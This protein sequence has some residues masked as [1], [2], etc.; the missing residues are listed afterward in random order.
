MRFFICALL[1]SS[2]ASSFCQDTK[3]IDTTSFLISRLNWNSFAF[4]E[5]YGISLQ[6]GQD[7][8]YLIE[9]SDSSKYSKLLNSIEDSTKTVIIH[10]ILTKLLEPRKGVFSSRLNYVNNDYH[11]D[12]LSVS[13]K[14]N[15]L[16]WAETSFTHK[17]L[18]DANE[19]HKI[20][21][22]WERKIYGKTN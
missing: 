14:Y 17:Y 9:I 4:A 6:I 21:E 11:L 16:S 20:K 1:S 15:N 13:Y 5:N 3:K 18:I 2:L 22:Y 7:A 19:I 10:V 12:I 8:Q